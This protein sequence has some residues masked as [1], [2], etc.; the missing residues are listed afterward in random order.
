[1]IVSLKWSE[2]NHGSNSFWSSNWEDLVHCRHDFTKQQCCFCGKMR[3]LIS[4]T[5]EKALKKMKTK[6]WCKHTMQLPCRFNA[7]DRP[8]VN[9]VKKSLETQLH[10]Q[11]M[12]AVFVVLMQELWSLS[13]TCLSQ[14]DVQSIW[15]MFWLLENQIKETKIVILVWASHKVVSCWCKQRHNWCFW[16]KF[17]EGQSQRHFECFVRHDSQIVKIPACFLFNLHCWWCLCVICI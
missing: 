8:L 1:M 17:T 11:Q 15:L 13:V 12:H 16:T 4:V 9:Q 7:C 5:C 14:V 3:C 6:H 10:E 2:Q